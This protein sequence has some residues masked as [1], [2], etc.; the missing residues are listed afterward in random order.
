[1]GYFA[2]PYLEWARTYQCDGAFFHPLLTCRTATNHLILA[3][4]R[5]LNKVKVPSMIAEGDIVD[6][7]LFDHADTMRKAD[8]LEEMMDHS[9]DVRQKEGLEW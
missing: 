8:V 4:D 9:R 3:Q 1:M 7:K 5:L 6:T 2:Y